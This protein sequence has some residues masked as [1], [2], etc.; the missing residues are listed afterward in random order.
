MRYLIIKLLI[1]YLIKLM[2]YFIHYI[3]YL[4]NFKNII[5]YLKKYKRY[6]EHGININKACHMKGPQLD[7]I[8]TGS[9]ITTVAI[10]LL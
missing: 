1:R 2:R 7:L 6:L 8:N 4:L 3:G 5:R 9:Y 10:K